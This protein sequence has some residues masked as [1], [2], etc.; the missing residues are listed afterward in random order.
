M[1]S[2][3]SPRRSPARLSPPRVG[4]CWKHPGGR[5]AAD[6]GPVNPQGSAWSYP[7][8]AAFLI[9][10]RHPST[11][12]RSGFEELRAGSPQSDGEWEARSDRIW[13]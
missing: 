12:P 11:P 1:T 8:G 5:V 6:A 2:S 9:A 3:A 10:I 13:Q 7:T 4:V